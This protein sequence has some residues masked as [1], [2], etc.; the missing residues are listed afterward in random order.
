M[1]AQKVCLE[2]FNFPTL[3]TL[4]IPL[5]ASAL[6]PLIKTRRSLRLSLSQIRQNKA[7]MTFQMYLC[8]LSTNQINYV[9]K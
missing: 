6:C 7:E 8:H 1:L 5:V 9:Q 3:Y 4:V 2:Y